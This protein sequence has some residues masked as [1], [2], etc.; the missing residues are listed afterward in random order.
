[1]VNVHANIITKELGTHLRKHVAA[2]LR[3]LDDG[4]TVPFIARYR[5]EATG[6]M[7]EVTVRTVQL[8][9]EALSELDKRKEY[10]KGVIKDLSLIHI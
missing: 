10:I 3:L 9:H 5:K 8:R 7:D 1:M 2:C 4:A 6:A